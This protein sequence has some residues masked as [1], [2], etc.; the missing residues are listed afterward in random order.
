MCRLSRVSTTSDPCIERLECKLVYGWGTAEARHSINHE[1]F[2][3]GGV[4]RT[5]VRFLCYDYLTV[6]GGADVWTCT[7]DTGGPGSFETLN[8]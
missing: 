7:A 6:S 4:I 5:T 8:V 2:S 3:V 1:S